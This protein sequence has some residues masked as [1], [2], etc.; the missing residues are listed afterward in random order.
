MD[1]QTLKKD[2]WEKIVEFPPLDS[3][4]IRYDFAYA[5]NNLINLSDITYDSAAL[6]RDFNILEKRLLSYPKHL[7]GL[8]YRDFQ[9]RN[10]IVKEKPYFIDYQS[11]R[12]GPGIY[13]LV[14]FAW[15]AKA[16]FS[17]EDKKKLADI[18]IY[19]S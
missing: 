7:W 6:Q 3:E 12:F 15:Q 9:S 2:E 4:L 1:F 17:S 19:R 10:I 11:C 16:G 8:M 5:V 13:D 18:Y 14:S